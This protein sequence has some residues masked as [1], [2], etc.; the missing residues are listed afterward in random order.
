MGC[1][2]ENFLLRVR[3]LKKDKWTEPAV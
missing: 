3:T 1:K 2:P